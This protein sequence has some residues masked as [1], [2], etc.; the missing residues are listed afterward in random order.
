MNHQEFNLLYDDVFADPLSELGFHPVGKTKSLR[1]ISGTRDL[2]IKRI[3]GKWPHPGVARTAICFRHRF[4]RPVSSDN[5][6][7][8]NL[9]VDDFSRKLTFEDFDGWLKP[10]L[11]YRPENAGRWSTSDIDYGDRP[12][13]QVEN[14]LRKM[15]KVVEKR[16]LPWVNALTEDGELAQ[17]IRSGEDAWCETR[18]IEDY[19]SFCREKVN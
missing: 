13:H 8:T 9:M 7:S 6:N 4:L 5:P 12:P 10:R 3:K 14:D 18:W 17:I 15:R 2:W 16:L 19:R 1:R 11:R